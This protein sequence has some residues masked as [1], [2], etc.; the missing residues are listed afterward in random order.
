ML[1]V[2]LESASARETPAL[3]RSLLKDYYSLI[4]D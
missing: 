2:Q 3:K 1:Q 4:K